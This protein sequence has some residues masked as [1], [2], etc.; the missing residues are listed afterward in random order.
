MYNVISHFNLPFSNYF[1]ALLGWQRIHLQCG[2]P[3]FD[4]WVGEIPWRR[5]W[6]PTP[7][8]L[9]GESPWTE[10][11]GRLQVT[12]SQTQLRDSAQHMLVS[13]LS[14]LL[15]ES[16]IFNLCYL[17]YCIAIFFLLICSS[18]L[19]TLGLPSWLRG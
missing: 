14:F 1:Y 6:Q 16:I 13:S 8:F 19:S 11:P 15:Q 17:F 12:K 10:E 4:P 5:A 7:V 3:G 2:R 18:F 9:P